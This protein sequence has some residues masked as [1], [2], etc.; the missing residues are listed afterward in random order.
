MSKP[1]ITPTSLD[2]DEGLEQRKGEHI[3]L[4]LESRMQGQENYFDRLRLPHRA[5]PEI[6]LQ[7]VSTAT[8]FLGKPVS[9]PL[10]I[11]AMTGGTEKAQVINRNLAQA[12]QSLGLAF[13]LGSQRAAVE[14]PDLASTYSVREV[15]PDIPVIANLGAIQ[16][17]YGYGLDQCQRAVEMVQADGLALHFNALQEAIQPEGQTDFSNL[18]GQLEPIVEA[19]E[20]PVIAK[21]V[22]HGFDQRS[23]RSLR[24]IGVVVVD[25]AGSGGTDWGR[26]EAARAGDGDLGDVFAGW[27]IPSPTAIRDLATITGLQVIGSGGIRNGVDGAKAISLGASWVAM[28]Q[29]FLRPA[30]ESTEQVVELASRW[31]RELRIAMFCCGVQTL[32]Q[33]S[34]V[35]PEEL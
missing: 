3:E 18:L 28:A 9:A 20:V 33:L 19:L 29:P 30:M 17:N 14:D 24:D 12:A 2:S 25:A 32:E 11:G 13:G 22:G 23:A 10:V 27:G 1:A 4:A 35:E 8:T 21:E 16:L 6:S 26:I 15:A 7:Q 34:G 31:L 5:M